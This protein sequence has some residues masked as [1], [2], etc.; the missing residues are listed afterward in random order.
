MCIRDRYYCLLFCKT[1]TLDAVS[2]THL[3]VYKR[4]PLRFVHLF[5][6][7]RPP[8]VF[9]FPLCTLPVTFLVISYIPFNYFATNTET[10]THQYAHA[11]A[12]TNCTPSPYISTVL[13][14]N[15]LVINKL[16]R[17]SQ[18]FGL[19]VSSSFSVELN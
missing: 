10:Y 16:F 4:Q 18:H 5:F 6:D 3:D 9:Y 19:T 1:L 17:I 13:G 8:R 7:F 11:Q 14:P 12:E 15:S 2:Y